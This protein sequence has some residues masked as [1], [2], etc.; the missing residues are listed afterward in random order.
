MEI[1]IIKVA[2][3]KDDLRAIAQNQFGSFVKAVVDIKREIMAIGAELHADEEVILLQHGSSQDDL[4]GI[5][6]HPDQAD[7]GFIE[8]NSMINIHPSRG[9][10]SRG[11]ED[12][13]IQQR[14]KEVVKELVQE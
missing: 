3:R 5:N 10:S 8:F 11:V 1:K 14:I 9:N 4:W 12:R 13:H 6:L 7:E 2:I